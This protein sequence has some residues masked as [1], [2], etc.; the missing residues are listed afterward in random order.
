MLVAYVQLESNSKESFS[1]DEYKA[2]LNDQMP[3]YSVPTL[4][5]VMEELPVTQRGK[6]DRKNLPTPVI[7]EE[8]RDNIIAPRSK[9]EKSSM[10]SGPNVWD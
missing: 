9:T 7:V 4:V 3:S 6:I 2:Y 1:M 5:M 10:K 8:K